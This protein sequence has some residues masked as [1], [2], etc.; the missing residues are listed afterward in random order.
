M[1]DSPGTTGISACPHF[2]KY[3]PLHPDELR[4]PYPSLAV[5]RRENPVYH[6]EAFNI[7][8][9]TRQ[10]D[11]LAILRDDENFS[12]E[13]A[14]ESYP[15]PPQL[16]ERMAGYPWSESV[17]MLDDPDHRPMRALVQAPFTPRSLAAR[18]PFLRERA[19]RL[20]QPLTDEG[21]IDFVN[22]YAIPLSLGAIASITGV[23][24]DKSDLMMRAVESEFRLCSFAPIDEAEYLAAA[25]DIAEL[26]EYFGELIADRRAHPRDDYASVMIQRLRNDQSPE[27]TKRIIVGLYD[28]LVAGFE[29]SAQMMAQ[30]VRSLLTHRD[31]WELLVRD[32][33]L[34][35]SAV[36][37]TL[38]QRT[39]VKRIFRLAKHEVSV[40]GVSIPAGGLV[41]LILASADHDPDVYPDPERL[42]ITRQAPHLAFGKGKHFCI[43]APLARIE[44][45]IT[46]EVLRERF[47]DLELAPD[48]ELEWRPDIRIDTINQLRL[49]LP[50]TA[51]A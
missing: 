28:I 20:L 37:E 19:K 3:D 26:Y 35:P 47:P 27:A 13:G 1:P 39:L 44:M 21:T 12:A 30:G 48:Q 11:V 15:L 18:E 17:L 10:A 43:G 33:A 46:L 4:D 2:A 8:E 42:D 31:Q 29:T 45:R 38:R 24:E 5:S 9:V 36:E 25:T 23:P 51:R 32:P 40:G 16:R 41:S 6:L 50:T 49:Q 14:L 7:W 34:V 22:E